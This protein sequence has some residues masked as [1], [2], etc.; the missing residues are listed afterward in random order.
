MTLSL[1]APYTGAWIEIRTRNATPHQK[2]SLPTRE[3]GLK[4]HG[5]STEKQAMAGRSLHGSVD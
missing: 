3:R 4:F 2:W 1:V 5:E